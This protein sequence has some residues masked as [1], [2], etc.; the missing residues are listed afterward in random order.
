MIGYTAG[1]R[2]G[3]GQDPA[4]LPDA[5]TGTVTGFSGEPTRRVELLTCCL[6]NSCSAIELRRLGIRRQ[7]PARRHL[8]VCHDAGGPFSPT[9]RARAVHGEPPHAHRRPRRP[10][11]PVPR[12]ALAPAPPRRVVPDPR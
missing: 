1:Y 7:R 2:S 5:R 8:L 4:A 6:Q 10:P 11:L 12:G 9:A 3:Y